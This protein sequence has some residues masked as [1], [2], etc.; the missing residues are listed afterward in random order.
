MLVVTLYRHGM[1]QMCWGH[2]ETSVCTWYR[3]SHSIAMSTAFL[4]HIC[5]RPDLSNYTVQRVELI[6][7]DAVHSSINRDSCS[8]PDAIDVQSVT[9][10]QQLRLFLAR[11]FRVCQCV[12]VQVCVCVQPRQLG[13]KHDTA[14]ICCCVPA[15]DRYL[16]PTACWAANLS[17]DL[18]PLLLSNDRTD[19]QTHRRSTI[20]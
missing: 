13:C 19:R 5:S 2:C 3:Q 7:I 1:W 12:C 18:T 17:H 8:T 20:S 11:T 14:R 9:N 6:I 15:V 10:I 4:L 16:L